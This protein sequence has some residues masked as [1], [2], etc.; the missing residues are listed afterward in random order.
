M[1]T[2]R[3]AAYGIQS[4]LTLMNDGMSRMGAA[5]V[6]MG[7]GMTDSSAIIGEAMGRNKSSILDFLGQATGGFQNFA[8]TGVAGLIGALTGEGGV[9]GAGKAMATSIVGSVMGMIPVVGPFISQFAGPMI[10]GFKKI[11][12][13]IMELFGGPG[14]DELRRPAGRQQVR[15][16]PS[17]NAQ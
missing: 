11:H 12:G 3:Q 4:D 5:G 13:K 16:K 17:V 6:V 15:S 8:K 10:E 9:V 7:Q 14:A 1:A 2:F